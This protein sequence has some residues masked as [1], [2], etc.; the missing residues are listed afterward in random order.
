M[1]IRAQQAALDELAK[2]QPAPTDLVE[3]VS[4]GRIAVFAPSVRENEIRAAA[5]VLEQEPI[6]FSAAE[7][8]P[9]RE[10]RGHLGAFEIVKAGG[11]T[12]SADIIAD[13]YDPPLAQKLNSDLAVLPPGYICAANDSNENA[14]DIARVFS[15]AKEMR[16]VFHKPKYFQ[17]DPDLC[18]HGASKINGCEQCLRACPAQAI[19]SAGEKVRVNPNLCQGCGL[20]ALVCPGG[21]MRYAYPP[22]ADTLRALRNAVA[23]YRRE[24]GVA[25]TIVFYAA[26]C[27][28]ADDIPQNENIIPAMMEEAGA[29]GMEIWLCALAYGAAEVW[30]FA[31]NPHLAKTARAQSEI[32]CA[33][34]DALGFR[35]A[36]HICEDAAKIKPS[37]KDALAAAASFAPGNDKRAMFFMA[38][39]H[40]A[41]AAKDAPAEIALPKHAPFGEVIVDAE[42]CTLCM[43]CAGVCPA[44]A[45]WA[46]GDSPRLSFVEENCLQCGLCETAC[47]EDAIQLHSRMQI[48]AEERRW[49][50]VLNEDRPL[51]CLQCGKPFAGARLIRRIE[52]KLEAHWMFQK[53][54][55]RRRLRLCEDCRVRD[56]FDK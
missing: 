23:A 46:G 52:K 39:N 30:V 38:L 19:E 10:I 25:P 33:I 53:P 31:D 51:P 37:A 11:E 4:R 13:F 9:V 32:V 27:A 26:E 56:M 12:F 7:D 50:R 22:P 18:A 20:C 40:L 42:K 5:A 45:V 21:A 44:S 15:E 41:A 24:S 49:P 47:P 17:Y 28:R 35:R 8:S 43:S 3:Y 34:T 54:E 36:L 1:R 14:D 48:N 2:V 16:G 55:E 6:I 29:A